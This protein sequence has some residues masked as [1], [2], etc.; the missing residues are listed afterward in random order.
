MKQVSISNRALFL[1]FVLPL[2][3]CG[4][5]EIVV[6]DNNDEPDAAQVDM[7]DDREEMTPDPEDLT[8]RDEDEGEKP[9]EGPA[10]CA[11]GCEGDTPFCDD[12]TGIC[13]AC[14]EAAD[15][16]Q[17]LANATASCEAGA[18]LYVCEDDAA[19]TVPP[20]ETITVSGCSCEV[21]PEV[22]DG[23]DNDCDGEVDEEIEPLECE[24]TSGVCAGTTLT[25]EGDAASFTPQSCTEEFYTASAE[26]RGSVYE[27]DDLEALR[28][29]GEDNDC[30]GE[31]DERAV[32]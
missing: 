15:C 1:G 24:K 13:V 14:R 27:T 31:I 23:V 32:P 2:T 11:A 8:D 26:Q 19:F 21:A 16:A 9:D 3:A 7:G 12:A 30:D 22:C 6:Q 29:D 28:C 5:P 10:T 17:D 25:C 18:C 20:G 4:G